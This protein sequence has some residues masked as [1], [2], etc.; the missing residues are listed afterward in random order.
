MHCWGV[1]VVLFSSSF[2][3][4]STEFLVEGGERVVKYTETE[5][6]K[7]A[8]KLFYWPVRS[9]KVQNAI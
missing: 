8:M 3:E 6:K 2:L 4:E 7:Q 1:F 9:S 5:K